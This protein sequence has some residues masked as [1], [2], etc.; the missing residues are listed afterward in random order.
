VQPRK[1]GQLGVTDERTKNPRTVYNH[2]DLTLTGFAPGK[3]FD[4]DLAAHFPGQGKELLAFNGKAGPLE[5]GKTQAVPVNGHISI[6]QISLAGLNSVAAGAIPPNTDASAT[7]DATITS[8]NGNTGC[9]GNL[10]LDNPVVRGAKVAYPIETQY[11]LS[12]NDKNEQIQVQ[13]GVIKIGPT[14]VNLSGNIDSGTTPSTLNVRLT[15]TNASLTE[16]S[17]LA[18]AFG[19]ASNPNDQIKGSLSADLTAKG[20]MTA[21]QVQGTLAASTLQAQELVLTNVHATCNMNNGVVQL[22][23]VTATVYGGQENGTITL[24]TKAAHPLCSVKTKLSGVDT[25]ALLSAVSSVKNTLY[26]NLAADADLRFA[27]DTSNNLAQTLNGGLTFG[28]TNGKLKN[29]NIMSELSKIGKFLNSAP[30]QS[31]TDT[32]L[33]KLAGTFDIKNGLATTNNLTAAMDTG[34]LSAKGSLNLV[35][36]GI[37]MHMNAVLASGVS[38]TVGGNSVGGFLNTALANKNGELVIPVIVT[39]TMAHP[40]FAPDV[41]QLAQMK[42]QHLLP[43]T[44]DPSK[45]T[46]GALGSVLGGLT[47]KQSGQQQQQQQQ[48]NPLNSIFKKLPK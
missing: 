29:I 2:I 10:R 3:Q 7:G 6:Q 17:R 32:K 14:V 22:S 39:G 13:S 1:D 5:A 35:N 15:T 43:T 25:N 21:P 33:Q 34:S 18:S 47:G 8:N 16:L 26:G 24:D 41:Q 46:S 48:Q 31:G 40:V 12:M 4:F 42:L 9:K 44:G 30:A 27:L 37:N 19:A 23:P 36:E 11:D 38:K 20:P 45:M 28:V